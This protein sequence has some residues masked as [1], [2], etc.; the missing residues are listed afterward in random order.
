MYLTTLYSKY[1]WFVNL[2]IIVFTLVA[3]NYVLINNRS[4]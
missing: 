4:V 1:F 3:V 2:H